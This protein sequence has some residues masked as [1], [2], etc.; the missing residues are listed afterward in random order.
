MS[1][2]KYKLL[3]SSG[4]FRML[5]L[6]PKNNN[7]FSKRVGDLGSCFNLFRNQ[8]NSMRTTGRKMVFKATQTLVNPPFWIIPVIH[9]S[10]NFPIS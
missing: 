9:T 3:T 5:K 7:V 1:H 8:N 4:K 6:D 2:T 10:T